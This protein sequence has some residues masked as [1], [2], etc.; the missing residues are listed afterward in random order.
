METLVVH[1]C[2]VVVGSGLNV[3][4]EDPSDASGARLSDLFHAMDMKQHV[5]QPTHQASGTLNLIVM[6]SDF[7]VDDLNVDPPG[8]VSDHSL[9]TGNLPYHRTTPPTPRHQVRT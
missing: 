8:A 3:H 1:G 9:I 6:F 2:P 5:T 7:N 4:V